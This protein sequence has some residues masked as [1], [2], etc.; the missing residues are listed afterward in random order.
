MRIPRIA[1][2]ALAAA[3]LTTAL[4]C[5]CST[6]S[7][8][9]P[10]NLTFDTSTGSFSFDAVDG[11][12]TYTVGVSKILNDTTGE[13][14]QS[15]NGSALIDPGDGE[16][17]YVWSEQTG[18]VSGLSDTDDDGVVDG[19]VVFRAFSSSASEVGDVISI[20]DLPVGH[21]V[22][23][24]VPTATDELA[25]PET[26]YYE[27]TIPGAL[28]APEGFTAQVNDEGH[29]E[30]TAPSDYYLSCFTETGL[31]TEMLFEVKSGDEVVETI[32]VDD[33][34]YTN[35]VNGPN[36]SFTF[37]NQTV[38][39][40]EQLDQDGDYT[41][42][43]TAVGDG[44]Q[45]Q[46]ASAEAYM[47]TTTAAATFASTYDL[48]G[49]GSASGF[50]VSVTLGTDASGAA[51]YELVASLNNVAIYRESG[52]FEASEEV[53]TY[54]EKTTFP[55]GATL[56]FSTES[57][58]FGSP[59]LDGVTLSVGTAEAM[60]WGAQAGEVNYCLEGNATLDGES[61]ELQSSAGGGMGPM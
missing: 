50:S 17:E 54:D 24:A 10:Q 2:A 31:P 9:A 19:T 15:I 60:G 40:T 48:T 27:F 26:A 12:S 25:N 43:V 55:E 4:L 59:V 5:G 34:S 13:A 21:Y 23:S 16:S 18:S 38:T 20:S 49:S 36:K 1:S 57:S 51:L 61:L 14:L 3:A 22:L 41:V 6:S 58:D 29:I 45:I 42:T 7:S 53:G 28:A 52:T 35:T 56:T 37:N 47:A 46:D 30:I 39:G 32:T 11:G 33:F 44:D 8:S